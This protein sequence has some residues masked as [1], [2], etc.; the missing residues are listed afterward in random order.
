MNTIPDN[1]NKEPALKIMRARQW[2]YLVASRLLFVQVVLTVIVPIVATVTSLFWPDLRAHFAALA[3]ATLAVDAAYL[4]REIKRLAK[5]GA[6]LGESFDCL[7]LYLAWNS[8]VADDPL[9]AEDIRSAARAWSRSRDDGALIDWYPAAVGSLP[10][11]LG[12]IVCQRTNLRYDSQLRRSYGV[13]ILLTI[14]IVGATLLVAGLVRDLNLTAWVLTLAPAAPLLSW[15]SREYFRQR[16][17]ADQLERVMRKAR[18]FWDRALSGTCSDYDCERESREFQDAIY[19]RRSTS[20][21][22]MPFVYKFKRLA[23][24]DEMNEAAQDFLAKYYEKQAA[25]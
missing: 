21:L 24:E 11:S 9:D 22:V 16:D 19:L 3:L 13:F 14:L 8:F 12:R 10:L 15:G 2:T 7:V 17:A 23:L 6:K 1:Q 4:D 20:P 18:S 25:S 5:K